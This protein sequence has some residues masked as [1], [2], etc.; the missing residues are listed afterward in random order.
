MKAPVPLAASS[1]LSA[2][3]VALQGFYDVERA[4]G[5]KGPCSLYMLSIAESGERKTSCDGYFK[6]AL[7]AWQREQAELLKPA[8]AGYEAD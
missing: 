3:S 6:Q 1:A 4:P 7:E 5:L 8:I 2:V